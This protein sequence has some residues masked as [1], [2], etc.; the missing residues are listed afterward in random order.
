MITATLRHFALSELSHHELV[1]NLA[2][3][4]LDDIRDLFGYPLTVTCAART[5]EENAALP[6]SAPTSLHLVGR[7]FDLRWIEDAAHRWAFV[8]AVYLAS[9]E[10]S[11]ELEF[12]PFGENRHI[13][14]ALAGDG[15]ASTLIF[16]EV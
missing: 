14:V 15:H 12:V 2:A 8:E 13:H 6:G 9:G 10:R 5:V 4:W 1:D 7:A 3:V 16:S 11:V